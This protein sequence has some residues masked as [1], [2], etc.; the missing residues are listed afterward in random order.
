MTTS[1]FVR[2]RKYDETV[3]T[4]SA[5]RKPD[6]PDV[7]EDERVTGPLKVFVTEAEWGQVMHCRESLDG[8]ELP[9]KYVAMGGVT[10]TVMQVI[11]RCNAE[12][13][14]EGLERNLTQPYD[15][16]V[17]KIAKR[18][19]DI[20][21]ADA[22]GA[23]DKAGRAI[24]RKRPKRERLSIKCNGHK[25]ATIISLSIDLHKPLDTRLIRLGL[26]ARGTTMGD[27]RREWDKVVDEQLV[28]FHSGSPSTEA[29][30]HREAFS[31]RRLVGRLDAWLAH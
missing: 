2:K 19:V 10:P 16:R 24:A 27:M 21:I 30:E 14:M 29:V 31:K 3:S 8:V 11:E 9:D 22:H 5:P 15:E 26:A 4:L 12:C 23:N 6:D 13:T 18:C 20:D 17:D 7:E 28:I 1:L 25:R